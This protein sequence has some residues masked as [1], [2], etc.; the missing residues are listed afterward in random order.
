MTSASA[1]GNHAK[2][3]GWNLGYPSELHSPALR[4]ESD[5][6]KPLDPGKT[7]GQIAVEYKVA[8]EPHMRLVAIVQ[9]E[10]DKD[11]SRRFF[12]GLKL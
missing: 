1:L 2:E 4:F 9:N 10:T 11:F 6:F 5:V 8:S 3:R 12:I 7:F